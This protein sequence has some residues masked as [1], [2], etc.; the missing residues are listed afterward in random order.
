MLGR[1]LQQHRHPGP[2]VEPLGQRRVL[3]VAGDH[4]GA[5]PGPGVDE[6]RLA[7]VVAGGVPVVVELA[8]EQRGDVAQRLVEQVRILAALLRRQEHVE[9]LVGGAAGRGDRHGLEP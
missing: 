2:A 7:V 5:P 8:A 9:D 1:V 3:P 4:A 6:N